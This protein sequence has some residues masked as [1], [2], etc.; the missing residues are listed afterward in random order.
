MKK[1]YQTEWQGINFDSFCDVSS[2]KIA[3]S[4]FY[5]LYYEEF[6]KKFNNFE[7]L[8]K[9]WRNIK[10]ETADLI[11]SKITNEERVLSV[12][13]GIGYIENEI[14][15]KLSDLEL[16]ASDFSYK[17]LTWLKEILTEENLIT[18]I[19]QNVD[20]YDL[21]YCVELEYALDNCELIALFK[22]IKSL[23]A[24]QGKLL[25]ITSCVFTNPPNLISRIKKFIKSQS[26]TYLSI[27]KGQLWGYKRSEKELL[28][29]FSEAGFS[30]LD[31]GKF[32]STTSY[33]LA[34]F[35]EEKLQ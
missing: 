26:Q 9:E 33:Y 1:F 15:K 4:E 10:N 23:L 25:I 13:C 12:G 31:S 8:P 6:F 21:I 22:N 32:I 11:I 24:P 30:I 20:S 27:K 29:I 34:T 3:D 35:N 17:S 2:S 7:S 14:I 19:P 16:F 28:Q 18:G 5:N